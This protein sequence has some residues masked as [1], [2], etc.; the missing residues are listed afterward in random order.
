VPTF[1]ITTLVDGKRKHA[2]IEADTESAA[3]ERAQRAGYTVQSIERLGSPA[4]PP[5]PATPAAAPSFAPPADELTLD[6]LRKI[7]AELTVLKMQTAFI[8]PIARCVLL[9]RPNSTL[10]GAIIFGIFFG[11]LFLGFV[12]GLLMLLFGFLGPLRTR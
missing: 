5:A 10:I 1:R 12:L 9:R 6:T 7:H 11:V 3:R 2:D 4:T 8:E